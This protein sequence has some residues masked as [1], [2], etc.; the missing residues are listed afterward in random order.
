M[1]LI[2]P[3]LCVVSG[4]MAVV[5]QGMFIDPNPQSFY[6][7]NLV[8]NC[9]YE[10]G[11][12]ISSEADFDTFNVSSCSTVYGDVYFESNET[13]FTLPSAIKTINGS[14]T[15]DRA[16]GAPALTA[17]NGSLS[18]SGLPSFAVVR[19]PSLTFVGGIALNLLDSIN[20]SSWQLAVSIN[21]S[22]DGSVF[23]TQ[24]NLT[25]V[26][27]LFSLTGSIGNLVIGNLS[28]HPF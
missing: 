27:G 15:L 9:T 4:I 24:T 6:L 12:F 13:S 2:F 22:D 16:P 28:S 23:V 26:A 25:S 14:L 21:A 17:I 19:F 5:S 11:L 3:I 1:K 20:M 7:Y 8:D 10:Y 18:L